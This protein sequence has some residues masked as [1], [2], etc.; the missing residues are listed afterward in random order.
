M[1]IEIEIDT[2]DKGP[3]S[4]CVCMFPFHSFANIWKICTE[5]TPG[6]AR[7]ALELGG[8]EGELG[9]EGG[10]ISPERTPKAPCSGILRLYQLQWRA[11]HRSHQILK[12]SYRLLTEVNRCSWC[13]DSLITETSWSPFWQ[14]HKIS[15]SIFLDHLPFPDA[16]GLLTPNLWARP[17][18]FYRLGGAEIAVLG[19][20]RV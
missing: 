6:H 4:Y 19:L 2:G 17:N 20:K 12:F 13:G 18:S 11:K 5:L 16:E 10:R 15:R 7:L 3:T 1:V 9:R 8:A 14:P